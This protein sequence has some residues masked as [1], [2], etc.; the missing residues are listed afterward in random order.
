[1][2]GLTVASSPRLVNLNSRST[3]LGPTD[4]TCVN[5]LS[6]GITCRQLNVVILS[7]GMAG[8]SCRIKSEIGSMVP[9]ARITLRAESTISLNRS[10]G[11][12]SMYLIVTI[13]VDCGDLCCGGM[14]EG[15]GSFSIES[16][17]R[18]SSFASTRDRRNDSTRW[19]AAIEAC[20]AAADR[21]VLPSTTKSQHTVRDTSYFHKARRD[22]EA[23][24]S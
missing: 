20:F 24:P 21:E 4:T 22:V 6:F 23:Y 15:V 19:K 2:G 12:R 10:A 13:G 7:L 1:V 16:K 14:C 3:F 18:P 11:L 9:P 8:K 17:I 5:R